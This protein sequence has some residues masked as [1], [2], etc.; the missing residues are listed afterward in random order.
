VP[1]GEEIAIVVSLGVEPVTV[2]GGLA[3]GGEGSVIE[4]LEAVPLS[5]A[6]ERR[7]D[8]DVPEGQVI[9]TSPGSGAELPPGSTVTVLVSLGVQPI[10]VPDVSGAETPLEAA[11][12]LRQEGLTPGSVSGPSEGMPSGTSPGAGSEVPPGTAVDIAL[13]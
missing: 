6:V 5:V 11:V 9:A 13:G 3:G 4:A 12:I 8:D 2:P 7:F 1:R 10:T